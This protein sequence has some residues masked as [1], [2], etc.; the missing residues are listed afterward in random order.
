[1]TPEEI[2]SDIDAHNRE[3]LSKLSGTLT[4]E[5][6]LA[7]MTAAGLYGFRMGSNTAM[8]MMKGAL[9]VRMIKAS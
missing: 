9:A 4:G 1:M 2:L 8:S 6:M 3:A 5:D 7:L